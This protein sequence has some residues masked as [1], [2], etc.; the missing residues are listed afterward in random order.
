MA[1]ILDHQANRRN[2]SLV[3]HVGDLHLDEGLR[4]AWCSAVHP[5]AVAGCGACK[6]RLSGGVGGRVESCEG[7]AATATRWSPVKVL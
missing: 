4:A 1:E 3:S 6:G 5:S 2:S 7:P